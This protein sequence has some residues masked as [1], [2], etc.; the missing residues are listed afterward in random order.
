MCHHHLYIPPGNFAAVARNLFRSSFPQKE[1]FSYLRK[2]GLRSILYQS[3]SE[4]MLMTHRTLVEGPYPAEHRA[5]LESAGIQFFQ[6][7]IPANKEPFAL[8]PVHAVI[9]ALS[10]LLDSSNHPILVHC[11]AGKHRTG[12]VIGVL[13]RL[14]RWA[15]TPVLVEYRMYAAPKVR[16]MDQLFIEMFDLENVRDIV[17]HVH[18]ED[19]WGVHDP[20]HA[21]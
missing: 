6:C 11:N 7:P 17:E 18:I 2:L 20:N 13:R 9:A 21:R 19:R 15:L 5:F 14:Q 16:A 1:N 3:L 4:F 10:I 12:C 8:M